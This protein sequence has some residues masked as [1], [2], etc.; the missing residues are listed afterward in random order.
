MLILELHTKEMDQNYDY[1]CFMLETPFKNWD[2]LLEMIDDEDVYDNEK[3]E[4]GKEDE[5]HVTIL[6]GL[7]GEVPFKEMKKIT[8]EVDG[9]VDLK[10]KGIDVFKNE[11]YDVL[12]LNIESDTLHK[13]HNEACNHPYTN[14]YDEYNPHM[15]VAYLKKGKGKKYTQY[16]EPSIGLN[17]NKFS[18][19]TVEGKK[20]YW[21]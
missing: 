14:E 16:F 20:Y 15:T 18:Y 11:E 3:G 4:F 10:I 7:H 21:D 8:D 19:S 5:P 1:N 9:S 6:Y 2:N 13:L 17:S 12:K